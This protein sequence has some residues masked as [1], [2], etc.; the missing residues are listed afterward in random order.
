MISPQL[1]LALKLD[2]DATFS[3]FY[4]PE[5]HGLLVS[6]LQ[7]Q[8]I[9]VGD[10]WVYLH[11]VG[12]RSHL[13]QACCHL[14]EEAGRYAR[15]IPLA[16]LVDFDPEAMLEGA[17]HLD[18]LCLDDI[19]L[20]AGHEQWERAIFNCYNRMLS[21][22]A[23][24]LISASV[25]VSQ[26]DVNL[27]DLQSRLQS[28]SSYRLSELSEPERMAALQ[29]KAKTRGIIISDAVAEYIYT[30]CK[31]DAKS[32]FDLLNVLDRLSLVEQRKLTIPFVKQA[33]DW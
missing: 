32:L 8:A 19:Q 20:I 18:L 15:Y 17:E 10:K 33:M 14:A 11:G 2:A 29:Y 21:T 5:H 30:R 4:T 16:E 12:G 9:G 3:N 7:Q 31:R 24:L 25:A 27:R 6:Q 13:L 1:P 22:D 23:R 26:L 28:L